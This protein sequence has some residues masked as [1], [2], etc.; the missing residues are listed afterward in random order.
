MAATHY[1]SQLIGPQLAL[2]FLLTGE[3]CTWLLMRISIRFEILV[4]SHVRVPVDGQMLTGVDAA[5]YGL[6][7]AA[8]PE[9]DVLSHAQVRVPL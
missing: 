7:V 6:V 8:V 5:K 9:A 3:V 1:T 2:K 4:Y